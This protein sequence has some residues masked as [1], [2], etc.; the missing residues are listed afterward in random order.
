MGEL[1]TLLLTQANNSVTET[2]WIS[3]LIEKKMRIKKIVLGEGYFGTVITEQQGFSML[4]KQKDEPV[5]LMVG[6]LAL[7]RT[8]WRGVTSGAGEGYKA[9]VIDLGSDW[10][11]VEE[12]TYLYLGVSKCQANLTHYADCLI[13][14]EE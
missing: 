11:D 4:S 2:G 7:L 5:N 8:T 3:R 12:D 1:R 6:I 9:V 10:I 14:Y 13:F